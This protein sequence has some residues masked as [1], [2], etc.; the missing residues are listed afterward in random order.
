MG[1]D[2][3]WALPDYELRIYC[4][5][6]Q[7]LTTFVGTQLSTWI[8]QFAQQNRCILF[9]RNTQVHYFTSSGFT[10]AIRPKVN[11]L[12]VVTHATELLYVLLYVK[13]HVDRCPA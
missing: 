9:L 2:K 8:E 11:T 10:F 12:M 13:E 6:T 1:N 4:L 5:I 7:K 3:L